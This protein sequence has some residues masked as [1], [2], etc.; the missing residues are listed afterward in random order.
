MKVKVTESYVHHLQV[1]EECTE[2]WNRTEAPRGRSWLRVS[3]V[4]VD[5]RYLCGHEGTDT[6]TIAI[7]STI[8]SS[9]EGSGRW[10]FIKA[11]FE[12]NVVG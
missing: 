10:R 1:L 3:R 7:L 8:S 11:V 5:D 12:G 9:R 6:E 4:D 2:A